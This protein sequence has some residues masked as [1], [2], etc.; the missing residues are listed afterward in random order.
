MAAMF[1]CLLSVGSANGDHFFLSATRFLFFR[2]RTDYWWY[3]TWF[4]LRGP[5]L[6]LPVVIFTDLP[7]VQLFVMTAV[8][9]TYMVM[10]L[11]T[12][13][14]KT[15]LIN[16]ADGA[17]SMMFILLLA[18]G[19]SFLDSLEGE[20]RAAAASL[21]VAVL[22]IL[23]FIAFVLL[24]LVAVAMLHKTAMGSA[25]E[26]PILT[27][28]RPPS[29]T[30]LRQALDSLH[31]A[32]EEAAVGTI[33]AAIEDLS[34]YD[35]RMLATVLTT[36]APYFSNDKRL[37]LMRR[38]S[39]SV[40]T[41]QSALSGGKPSPTAADLPSQADVQKLLAEELEAERSAE[42]EAEEAVKTETVE[43]DLAAAPNPSEVVTKRFHE[44]MQSASV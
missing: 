20:A 37:R 10:Q 27:L 12:W 29:N 8:L 30:E 35:R 17:M 21:A 28:G 43:S 14:W 38:L 3:G 19:A 24:C 40:T 32:Y 9:V 34:V 4:I 16:L 7:Q 13:P 26:L 41:S 22:G 11:T 18:V 2:F 15:P 39:V 33:E 1:H 42:E 6:S 36:L 44:K 5:L 31:A 25:S 23:Y